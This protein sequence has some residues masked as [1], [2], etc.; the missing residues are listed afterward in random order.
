MRAVA[1]ALVAAVAAARLGA[2]PRRRLED[3][4]DMEKLS[5]DA[6]VGALGSHVL[7]KLDGD[8]ALVKRGDAAAVTAKVVDALGCDGEAT[9]VFRHAGKHEAAHAAFGLD[10]WYEVACEAEGPVE[11]DPSE[12]CEDSPSWYQGTKKSKTCAWVAEKPASRCK[13]TVQSKD[14]VAAGVACPVACDA[15]PADG[16]DSAADESRSQPVDGP[17][18]KCA[19]SPSWY[20]GT[21]NSK[22]CAWVG[23]SPAKRCKDTVKSSDGVTASDAC[24]EACDGCPADVGDAPKPTPKPTPKP[25]PKPTPKPTPAPEDEPSCADSPSWYQGTKKSKTCAWVAEKPKSRCKDT[26]KSRDGVTAS[27]ACPEA[28][29]A[30]PADVGDA[31]PCEDSPTWYQGKKTT[32]TCAWVAK[33][34][35]KYCAFESRAKVPASAACPVACDSCPGRPGRRLAAARQYKAVADSQ[36]V[37]DALRRF[38]DSDAHDGVVIVE[39]ELDYATSF[40]PD[41]PGLNTQSHYDAINL[42]E[43]WDLTTGDPNVVVQVL[44]TGIEL[45]HPDLQL[46]IWTN[47][48]EICGNGVDDDFNGYVDDCHG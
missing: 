33:K 30:C 9:R 14:G 8:D 37:Y 38:L 13:D 43:A 46:N 21:K 28:C 7:F 47:P 22:T 31:A 34:P 35:E 2:P 29:D 27:V 12:Q 48:G 18:N 10:L 44:D 1:Y 23:K 40:T 41:D 6:A 5:E 25:A 26:I 15:C 45:D 4:L 39:P 3:S 16:D 11:G 36:S 42:R 19:D 24:P 32:R 20:Q 17:V